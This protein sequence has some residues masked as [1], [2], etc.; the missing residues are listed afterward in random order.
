VQDIQT[1]PIGSIV[2]D[3]Y[4]VEN[5]LG[6]GGFGAVYLVRDQRVRHN[7]FALK[8]LI[9]SSNLEREHFTFEGEVLKR[10]DHPAFPRIYRVFNDDRN[11][12]AYILM[13]Y[14]EGSN[15]E[16]LRQQQPENRFSLSQVLFLMAPIIDAVS[17]LHH[18][19]PPIL[20]RDIKPANII[21]PHAGDGTVLVDFGIAK[22]YDPD[23]TTTAIR[24]CSP[25]Y[26]APE[27]YSQGTSTHTD[28][29]GLGATIYALL[30]GVVPADAFY[31]MTQLGSKSIDPL[32]PVNHLVPSIP[33]PVANAIHQAM[34]IHSEDRLPTVEEFWRALNAFPSNVYA[35]D[36]QLLA[37]AMG[38]ASAAVRAPVGAN[39]NKVSFQ[40]EQQRRSSRPGVVLLLL[41][42]LLIGAGVATAFFA[43]MGNHPVTSVTTPTTTHRPTTGHRATA[44]SVR[45]TPTPMPTPT[46]TAKPA[47]LPNVAGAHNGTVH[48][49][50]GGITANMS[51]SIK[52]N[53]QAISG[54]V[55][56]NFPLEGSGPLT[57]SVTNSGG[58]QFIDRSSQV[59]APLYFWGTV[60]FDGSMRGSYCSLDATNRCNSHAGGAGYWNVGPIVAES[61]GGLAAKG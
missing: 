31:R 14:V 5:L 42:A 3:R 19:V 20:H 46:P 17:Y 43:S 24:R 37:S 6:K 10:V 53:G 59:S 11:G 13:D 27:Q 49:T 60:Q 30:T 40:K 50:T 35:A 44:T 23:A 18:Q 33:Q 28:V 38:P 55:T 26:G 16:V 54:Y 39:D 1:L 32:Q 4:I 51:L 29:Y 15:L 45:P 61:A 12:R 41:A 58:I 2:G 25:G 34:A 52:Q 36:Q 48:N 9:D 22:E 21:V 8:E 47:T 56:I 7:L 57:G